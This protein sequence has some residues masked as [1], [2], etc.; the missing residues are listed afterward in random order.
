MIPSVLDVLREELAHKRT[1]NCETIVL[2]VTL[3]EM[4]LAMA[5]L[6]GDPKAATIGGGWFQPSRPRPQ[7]SVEEQ[8]ASAFA[9]F[10]GKKGRGAP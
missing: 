5:E 6:R 1:I 2:S 10:D 7:P 8:W 9:I 3:A 4:L